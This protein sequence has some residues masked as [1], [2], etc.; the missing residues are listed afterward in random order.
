MF[1]TAL[2]PSPVHV[3]EVFSTVV[4]LTVLY[5]G[6]RPRGVLEFTFGTDHEG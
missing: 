1:S 4:E 5:S 6:F 2:A 3:E